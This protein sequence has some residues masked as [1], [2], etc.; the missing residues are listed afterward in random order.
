MKNKILKK[1]MQ[2]L[3]TRIGNKQLMLLIHYYL[4]IFYECGT[5][6]AW[7]K[8]T[9]RFKIL[10]RTNILLKFLPCNSIGFYSNHK[11]LD[12]GLV[13]TCQFLDENWVFAVCLSINEIERQGVLQKIIPCKISNRLI[14]HMTTFGALVISNILK[15][16]NKN[17]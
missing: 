17:I 10:C 12:E 5:N 7:S 16:N 14:Y 1:L 4:K 8:Y 13:L 2:L 15:I 3:Y 9:D 11:K 6:P